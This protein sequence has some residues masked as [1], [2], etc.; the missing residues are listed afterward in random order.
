MSPPVLLD[1]LRFVPSPH[2]LSAA[3]LLQHPATGVVARV[4]TVEW[5]VLQRFDGSNLECVRRRL[6]DECGFELV[7]GAL[8]RFVV[9]A[10]QAVNELVSVGTCRSG[11][12]R[13]PLHGL[14]RFLVPR[15]IRPP[16]PSA[17]RSS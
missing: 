15:F 5:S 7:P 17:S 10:G 9:E 11:A 13:S 6:R 14:R 8:E 4:G 1:G 16:S 12:R 2:P 3:G